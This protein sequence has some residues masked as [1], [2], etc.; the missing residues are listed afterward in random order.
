MIDSIIGT[1][2]DTAAWRRQKASG[3]DDVR[4]I[5]AAED[6]EAFCAELRQGNPDL[7]EEI[8][9]AYEANPERFWEVVHEEVKS[10]GFSSCV[11]S[12]E[13]LLRSVLRRLV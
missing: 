9:E 4:N 2:E 13:S 12:G 6:L 1:L 8:S 5:Q 7:N 11:A 3:Y 10:V